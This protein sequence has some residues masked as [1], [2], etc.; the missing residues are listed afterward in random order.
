M[1]ELAVEEEPG[2]AHGHRDGGTTD[3]VGGE[4]RLHA[5][6]EEG[7]QLDSTGHDVGQLL[8]TKQRKR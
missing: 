4:G 8:Q 3:V 7:G 1:E 5:R 2:A 6:H